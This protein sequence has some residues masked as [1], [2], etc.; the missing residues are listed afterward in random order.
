MALL[1]PALAGCTDPGGQPEL[2]VGVVLPHSGSLGRV[3][4]PMRASAEKAA[5]LVNAAGGAAGYRLRLAHEDSQ[6]QP[7]VGAALV[8]KLRADGASAV[9]G[10]VASGVTRSMLEVAGPSRLLLISPGSSSPEFTA[11][12]RGLDPSERFF[13]RTTPSDAL[14]GRVAA[15]YA[16]DRGWDRVALLHANNDYGNGLQAVFTEAFRGPDATDARAVV[17]VAYE[18]GQPGYEGPLEQAFAGCAAPEGCPD[19]VFFAGYPTEAEQVVRAWWARQDWRGVPWLFSEAE[20][21]MFERLAQARVEAVDGFEGTAHVGVGP[22]WERFHALLPELPPFAAPAFDAVLLI[23]L[24]AEKARSR[25]SPTLRDA[26]RAVAT[27]PGERLGPEDFARAKELLAAGQDV[28]YEGAA[29]GQNLDEAGDVTSAYEIFRVD[30]E[31]RISRKC[32]IAEESVAR[33][34]PVLPP[35]CARS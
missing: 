11:L 31:G 15:Q 24:A 2:L 23:A 1:G 35:E 19:A 12:L 20:P 6:T 8:H 34:P 16:L 32:F 29:G 5:E 4:P 13:A 18:E 25:D 7:G 22:G 17:V 21:A 30:G 33:R 28:D 26:L 14:R 10:E 27:P 9:V 3:G